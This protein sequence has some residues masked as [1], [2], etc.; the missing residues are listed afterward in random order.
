MDLLLLAGVAGLLLGVILCVVTEPL[1]W[2]W[3][4]MR[5]RRQG[6]AP[7]LL[8]PP[9]SKGSQPSIPANPFPPPKPRPD[10]TN[11]RLLHRD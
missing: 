5:S 9:D 10:R 2:R 3:R 4:A 11:P 6:S 7:P 1:W 8:R